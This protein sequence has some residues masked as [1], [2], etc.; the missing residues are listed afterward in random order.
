[1]EPLPMAPESCSL[2]EAE[3]LDQL[4]RYRAAGTGATSLHADARRRLIRLDEGVPASL[5]DELIAV[6]RSCCPFFELTWE[7]ARRELDIKVAT[8]E[9]EPA[10]AAIA[11]A[12]GVP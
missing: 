1:M 8:D 7:P 11:Q 2:T 10:L 5:V 6:E 9:D 3:L 12:L 4:T